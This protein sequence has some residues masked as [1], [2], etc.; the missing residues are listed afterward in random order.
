M[1]II[2]YLN[3]E[4]R[5]ENGIIHLAESRIVIWKASDRES[6]LQAHYV[7]L[8]RVLGVGI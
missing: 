8:F 4:N 6:V 7:A 2:R 5:I 1:I 3:Y